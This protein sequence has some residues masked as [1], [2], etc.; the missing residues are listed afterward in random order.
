M[1]SGNYTDLPIIVLG[2]LGQLIHCMLI[3]LMKNGGW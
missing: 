1:V 2:L 3:I